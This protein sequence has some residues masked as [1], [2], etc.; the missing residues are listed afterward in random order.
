MKQN[1]NKTIIQDCTPNIW[2]STRYTIVEGSQVILSN[3]LEKA[4]NYVIN[5]EVDKPKNPRFPLLSNQTKGRQYFPGASVNKITDE[6][7]HLLVM[8]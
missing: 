7:L 1:P 2:N 6:P 5:Q 4:Y 3:E 8:A